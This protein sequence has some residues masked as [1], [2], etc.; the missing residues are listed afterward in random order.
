MTAAYGAS[1]AG[2][3]WLCLASGVAG[4]TAPNPAIGAAKQA[5][6]MDVRALMSWAGRIGSNAQYAVLRQHASSLGGE[7]ASVVHD[8]YGLGFMFLHSTGNTN[9]NE[10]PAM[11]SY[12]PPLRQLFTGLFS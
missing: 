1:L 12:Q 10:L 3:I 9:N 6:Y 2:S 11:H 7:H 4:G 8:G 5:A